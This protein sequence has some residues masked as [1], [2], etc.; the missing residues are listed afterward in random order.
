MGPHWG[1]QGLA[2][3]LTFSWRCNSTYKE[4]RPGKAAVAGP[5]GEGPAVT[6]RGRGQGQLCRPPVTVPCRHQVWP[7]RSASP[8]FLKEAPWRAPEVFSVGPESHG[9]TSQETRTCADIMHFCPIPLFS[10]QEVCSPPGISRNSPPL[11]SGHY[12]S[13][14]TLLGA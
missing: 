4:V 6:G 12:G 14:G 9:S 13:G 2:M 11:C 1:C 5:G 7:P 10:Q 3:N 8:C